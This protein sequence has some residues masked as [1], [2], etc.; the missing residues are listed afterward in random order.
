MTLCI[1]EFKMTRS[2][3]SCVLLTLL[4]AGCAKDTLQQLCVSEENTFDIEQVSNLEDA[5]GWLGLRDAINLEF[6]ASSLNQ[7]GTWRISSV[8]VLVLVAE[9]EFNTLPSQIE[10]ELEV[11]D[12][13]D[14]AAAQPWSV[15][16]TLDKN[17][18][19]WE[20]VV[21]PAPPSG[22]VD[23]LSGLFPT[24]QVQYQAWWSFDFSSI[25]PETGMTSP[26]FSVAVHWPTSSYPTLGYSEF[27]RPCSGN[28]TN[29][30]RSEPTH[31][32]TG[33]GWGNNGERFG[34]D[35]CNWPMFKVNVEKRETSNVCP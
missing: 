22:P 32:Y 3:L 10:L 17:A 35:V 9:S 31:G 30:D 8:E 33:A 16:Q 5:W 7:T 27:N 2:A 21:L 34:S 11:Y 15:R 25:I 19:E 29:Y 20:R 13:P 12:A 28:W 14:P 1:G 4:T 26:A 24:E 23:E 18:L 6:D